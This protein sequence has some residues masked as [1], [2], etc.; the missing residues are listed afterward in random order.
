[1]PEK[2][3]T[4]SARLK[5]LWEHKRIKIELRDERGKEI[6][7]QS[8]FERTGE[9]IA[10]TAHKASRAASAAA[11]ALEDGVGTARRAAKQGYY[12]AAELY[13]DTKRRV[14]RHPVEAVVATFAAGIAAGTAIS[15]MVRRGRLCNEADAREKVDSSSPSLMNV[16]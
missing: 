15:W 4:S 2:F 3:K 10:D 1:M 5:R 6:M 11:D 13:D 16:S 9:Q 12:A 8:M 14:Q 7:M